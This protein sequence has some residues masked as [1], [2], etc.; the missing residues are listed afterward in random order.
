MFEK[1][2]KNQKPKNIKDLPLKWIKTRVRKEL[3]EFNSKLTIYFFQL[4]LRVL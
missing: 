1:Y 4:H 2:E 3:W